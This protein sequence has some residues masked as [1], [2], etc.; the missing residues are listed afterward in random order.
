MKTVYNSLVD[1]LENLPYLEKVPT[2]EEKV[3]YSLFLNLCKK[4]QPSPYGNEKKVHRVK[5][6]YHLAY[7]LNT[8]SMKANDIYP[9]EYFFYQLFMILDPKM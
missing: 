3:L 5:L 1:F 2:K 8:F 9:E 7:A 4:F 6:K